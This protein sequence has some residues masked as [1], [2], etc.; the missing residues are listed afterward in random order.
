MT[1][2]QSTRLAQLEVYVQRAREHAGY[3]LFPIVEQNKPI[4]ELCTNVLAY[5]LL[6]EGN[7]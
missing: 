2:Q 1:K 3:G 6:I 7:N 4:I 5:I